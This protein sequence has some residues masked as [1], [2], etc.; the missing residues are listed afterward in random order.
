LARWRS[1]CSACCVLLQRAL[2]RL[3]FQPDALLVWRASDPVC[4]ASLRTNGWAGRVV[5]AATG[6][7]LFR[8]QRSIHLAAGV[9]LI[10][11]PARASSTCNISAPKMTDPSTSLIRR[12]S[13]RTKALSEAPAQSG[14]PW[15]EPGPERELSGRRQAAC[16]AEIE[17]LEA[18]PAD[19]LARTLLGTVAG[20]SDHCQAPEGFQDIWW[21][22]WQDLASQ[23]EQD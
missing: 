15:Q 13:G 8:E 20:Q 17:G 18:R 19:L 22:P 7:V 14:S 16:L 12:R 11:R 23:A 9:V 4:A 5:V 3:Q 6:A 1:C 10:H 21:L 2:L